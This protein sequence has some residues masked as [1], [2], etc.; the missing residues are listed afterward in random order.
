MLNMKKLS[1]TSKIFF[2]VYIPKFLPSIAW[3]FRIKTEQCNIFMIFSC[4]SSKNIDFRNYTGQS[5]SR[6]KSGVQR[7]NPCMD[8]VNCNPTIFNAFTKSMA[9]L[10]SNFVH[11]KAMYPEKG[12]AM[13]FSFFAFSL[14]K[15]L[16]RHCKI[17]NVV[18]K[19]LHPKYIL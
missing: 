17:Y 14:W 4:L 15:I 16:A 8:T 10:E 5:R 7:L 13:T 3:K 6:P 9:C 2:S 12:F 1:G 18:A 11:V 19:V